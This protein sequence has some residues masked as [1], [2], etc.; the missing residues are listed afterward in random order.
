MYTLPHIVSSGYAPLLTM[1]IW[2]KR[3][4]NM[5]KM[6]VLRNMAKNRVRRLSEQYH[7]ETLHGFST[8]DAIRTYQKL[9]EA[10]KAYGAILR[11]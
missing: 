7:A 2:A 4:A 9:A 10:V 3:E 1:P 8:P 5:T 6:E 11:R